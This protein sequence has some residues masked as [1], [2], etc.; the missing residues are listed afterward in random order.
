[1]VENKKLSDYV[2]YFPNMLD[3]KYCDY[4]VSEMEKCDKFIPLFYSGEAYQY[5]FYGI[6]LEEESDLKHLYFPIIDPLLSAKDKYLEKIDMYH[7]GPKKIIEGIEYFVEFGDRVRI[8]HHRTGGQTAKH[9]DRPISQSTPSS[10][11][12]AT[13]PYE[14]FDE[15]L[16]IN[17]TAI[18]YVNED[19]KGGQFYIMDEEYSTEK[20]SV[21]IFPS[22]FLWPHGVR[23]VTEGERWSISMFIR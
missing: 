15:V 7:P 10:G 11:F 12:S 1:M 9:Y 18:L 21:I 5:D 6:G 17:L 3:K 4:A 16:K 8:Q 23:K 20:G 13:R 14:R 2:Q 19:Y 22:G